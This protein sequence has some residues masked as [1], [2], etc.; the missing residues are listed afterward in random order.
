MP[1]LLLINVAV[2]VGFA[3]LARAI[4]AA[5]GVSW[6]RLIAASV[7]GLLVGLV[8]ASAL[9][10][11]PSAFADASVLD[12]VMVIEVFA[13][14][15][16]FQLIVT[17]GVVVTFELISSRP[18]R[19]RRLAP[20]RPVQAA[21]RR[22]AIA[23][24]GVQVMR[25]AARHGLAAAAPRHDPS[26]A[27]DQA[28]R[29]RASIED[30]GGVY[31]KLGQ[32]LATRPD[33]LPPGAVEELGKLHASVR[34]LSIEQVR[35]VI[36]AELGD[37]DR[38]FAELDPD[39]LGS[40][41]IGQVHAARTT[42]G[43]DVVVKV[44]R[45]GLD[46][47]VER[48]LAILDWVADAAERRLTVAKSYGVAKLTDDFAEALREELDFGNEARHVTEIEAAIRD[49]PLLHAPT[50]LHQYSTSRV[51]VMERLQG[52]PL[53]SVTGDPPA[54]HRELADA[55]CLSQVQAMMRGQR[56]HGDPHPGNVLLLDDGR[57]G[58]IDFGM[59]GKLDAYGRAFVLEMLV[60]IR[61]GDAALLYEALLTGGSVDL[62][63][64]R[65]DI[66]RGLA[67]FLATHLSGDTI[68]GDALAEL[69][70][71]TA[72]LGIALPDQA[73]LM[74]RAVAT[75]TGTLEALSPGYPLVEVVSQ[76][77]GLEA[78]TAA[79]PKSV[80]E[81]AQKEA[82]TLV[83]FLRRLPRHLDLVA[84]QLQ[85]GQLTTKVSLFSSPSDVRVL[86][87]LLNRTLL[88]V[89][90]LGISALSILLIRTENGPQLVDGDL[91]LT[92]L[93]GW[94]SIFLGAVL[95]LRAL[96]DVLRTDQLAR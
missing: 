51:L 95:A 86:E 49:Y 94:V 65:D 44:Q 5:R 71:V 70:H 6:V 80:A 75:L 52:R 22:G 74:M 53:A 31:V 83:P 45:P 40:A 72:D 48:D 64:D 26:D 85:R 82:A 41:S 56:F 23:G 20:L 87:R 33:L 84:T 4:L 32:L 16:P 88:T 9:V 37:P 61:L 2:V 59:T 63:V 54:N 78:R 7:V 91:Y 18:R 69:V 28:R 66:E 1:V 21:R 30:L 55:L 89:L 14:A 46:R 43:T 10:V 93:I 42:D 8:V 62:D 34:P 68:S 12:D 36:A 35:G 15:V 13:V 58:L 60:A 96:L 57:L 50:V 25:V 3:F 19:R 38:V 92:Q 90:G 39:P 77:A 73:S 24:R 29:L 81:L 79:M 76:A 17:M 27:T 47:D 11:G 67:A